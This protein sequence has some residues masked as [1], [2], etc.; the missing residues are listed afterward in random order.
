MSHLPSNTVLPICTLPSRRTP[1]LFSTP[2]R[3]QH[4]P[5][6]PSIRKNFNAVWAPMFFGTYQEYSP[7]LGTVAPLIL[8]KGD[9]VS[10]DDL[11][12]DEQYV[13]IEREGEN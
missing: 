11:N 4:H 9:S 5:R 2:S 1:R 10:C 7:G 3:L 8:E 13:T 12:N 6:I